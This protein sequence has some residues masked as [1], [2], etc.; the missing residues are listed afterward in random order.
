MGKSWNPGEGKKFAKQVELGRKYYVVREQ[1]AHAKTY[2]AEHL[3]A[4][5][6]FTRRSGLTAVPMTDGGTSAVALCRNQ[7]PVYEEPPAGMDDIA[8]SSRN[9]RFAPPGIAR[10]RYN[11]N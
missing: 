3:Y 11:S 1:S 8:D 5:H 10:G 7:G 2:G 4:V 9:M 6:I